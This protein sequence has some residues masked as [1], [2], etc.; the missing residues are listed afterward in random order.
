MTDGGLRGED[1]QDEDLPGG[2][3]GLTIGKPV[4]TQAVMTGVD[5]PGIRT[6]TPAAISQGGITSSPANAMYAAGVPDA[7]SV[8]SAH[9]SRLTVTG[10]ALPKNSVVVSIQC[11][12]T[13]PPVGFSNCSVAQPRSLHGR[14]AFVPDG[15]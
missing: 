10:F 8:G 12:R 9:G 15:E 5:A 7:Q 6:R 1:R 3:E 4:D 13:R 2:A 14:A 11:V